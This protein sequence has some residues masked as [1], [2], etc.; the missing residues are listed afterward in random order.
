MN[1]DLGMTD[2]DAGQL[3]E[4]L[5][6]LMAEKGLKA[7]ALSYKTRIPQGRISQLL[8]GSKRNPT[9]ATLSALAA[10][11][12]VTIDEL[13]AVHSSDDSQLTRN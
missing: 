6:R 11:L 3:G 7:L 4:N 10:G 5:R 9:L 12:E 13:V 8:D 2:A 1:K